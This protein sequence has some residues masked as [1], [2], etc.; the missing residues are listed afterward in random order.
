MN[1]HGTWKVPENDA[2][3]DLTLAKDSETDSIIATIIRKNKINKNLEKTITLR[4]K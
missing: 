1:Q 4:E 2:Y 3:E